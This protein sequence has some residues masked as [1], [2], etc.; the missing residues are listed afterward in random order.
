MEGLV[1]CVPNFSEGGDQSILD[2][3]ALSIRSVPE[4]ELLDVVAGRDT[5]RSVFTFVGS[6]EGVKEGAF[7]AIEAASRHIDMT[8]HSGVHPRLGATDVCPF[9]PLRGV[10]MGDCVE[11]ARELGQRV[12]DELSIP[13]FLY[14]FAASSLERSDLATIRR[15]E[16]EKLEGKL[17]DP[18]WA[19]DFGKPDFNERSGATVIGA[20][21]LLIAYNVNLDSAQKTVAHDIALRVRE[22]GRLKHDSDGELITVP[23]RLKECKA[24]G[25][26]IDEYGKAQVSMN[27]TDYHVTPLHTAF[28]TVKDEARKRGIQVTGSEL[29]GLV[30]LEAMLMSGRFYLDLQKKNRAVPETELVR[31]ASDTLGLHE[32]SPFDPLKKI[33]DYRVRGMRPSNRIAEIAT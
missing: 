20:R 12:A 21:K 5:N 25:W 4:V 28:E 9:I 26:V 3:I 14:G 24:M 29:V 1:E 19:P 32:L 23:G 17:R 22:K 16:Y 33:I 11:M 7:R 15:G 27:L 10:T 13:V 2:A 6:R 31:V 8:Q 18:V 30:P